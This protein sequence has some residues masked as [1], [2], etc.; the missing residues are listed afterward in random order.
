LARVVGAP[1][2]RRPVPRS[3]RRTSLRDDSALAGRRDRRNCPLNALLMGGSG[4]LGEGGGATPS[5]SARVRAWSAAPRS[6]P[7][8]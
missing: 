1:P 2:A 6:A 7:T 5:R 4:E 3:A 8:R